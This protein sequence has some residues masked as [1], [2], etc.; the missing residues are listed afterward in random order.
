MEHDANSGIDRNAMEVFQLL[1]AG[2]QVIVSKE[3]L[4][5]LMEKD[6]SFLLLWVYEFMFPRSFIYY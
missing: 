2:I 1:F 4:I 5:L 6:Y 3:I